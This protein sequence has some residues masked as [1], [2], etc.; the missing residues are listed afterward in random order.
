MEKRA[1]VAMNA[2]G[3]LAPCNPFLSYSFS[4]AFDLP[5]W[6]GLLLQIY[7]TKVHATIVQSYA[8]SGRGKNRI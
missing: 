6:S 1:E 3:Q 2:Q 7:D 4:K 8:N 5:W